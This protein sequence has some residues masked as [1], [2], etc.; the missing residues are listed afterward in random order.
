M[1]ETGKE[2][3]SIGDNSHIGNKQGYLYWPVCSVNASDCSLLFSQR[4]MLGAQKKSHGWRGQ[5][6]KFGCYGLE[7]N[8]HLPLVCQL[9]SSL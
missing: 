8:K 5:D 9:L 4:V 3:V 7:G 6:S 1:A 2:L